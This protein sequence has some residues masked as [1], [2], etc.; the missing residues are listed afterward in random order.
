VPLVSFPTKLE[1]VQDSL[2][3]W[4]YCAIVDVQVGVDVPCGCLVFLL[5]VDS[6]THNRLTGECWMPAV[7]AKIVGVQGVSSTG[8]QQPGV[9]RVALEE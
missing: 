5:V 7:D 2:V 8:V 4:E 6:S 1:C 3:Y 9:R